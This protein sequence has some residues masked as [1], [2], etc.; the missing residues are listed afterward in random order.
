MRVAAGGDGYCG[1][2]QA[3]HLSAR[4]Y[5]VMIVD[6]L[7]R[8]KYDMELGMDTLTPISSVH[9]RVKAWREVSGKEVK[10]E[11]GDVCDWVFLSQVRASLVLG[12]FVPVACLACVV[13][14]WRTRGA[15]PLQRIALTEGKRGA[16]RPQRSVAARLS[17]PA[18]V[19]ARPPRGSRSL[20]LPNL[21]TGQCAPQPQIPTAP[22]AQVFSEFE[23]E[24]V[25]HFG[26]QRS[27]PYSMI[28]RQRS[29]YTQTNNVMGSINLLY[30]IKEFAPDCH[31]V[32]LG[33]MGEYGTPN[34]DIEEG[35]LEVEHNGRKGARARCLSAIRTL[36]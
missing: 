4:G 34:I 26:E 10:L 3:L 35:Y 18:S 28:D 16:L 9:E 29:I 1:W 2:A 15:K 13:R 12:F 31:M 17:Y 14:A 27:A 7:H 21:P 36:L 22:R 24:A 25:V 23:P 32:K 8:R 33:T 6:N 19:R 30:A 5:D 11:I 20:N